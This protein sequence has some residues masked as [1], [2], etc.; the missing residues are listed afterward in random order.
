MQIINTANNREVIL[1]FVFDKRN[2]KDEIISII[3]ARKTETEKPVK[4][5]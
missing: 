2:N 1:S 4:A 3:P 5:I